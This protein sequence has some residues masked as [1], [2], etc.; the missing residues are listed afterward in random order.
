MLTSVECQAKADEKFAQADP[1][2]DA[3]ENSPTVSGSEKPLTM[4][5]LAM[6]MPSPPCALQARP[7]LP[8]GR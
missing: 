4:A 2:H 1:P 3:S 7:A 6:S 5:R 8:T